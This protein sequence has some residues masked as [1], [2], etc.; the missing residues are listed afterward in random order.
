MYSFFK[1]GQCVGI[2]LYLLCTSISIK[3][4]SMILRMRKIQTVWTLT[5]KLKPGQMWIT[6]IN[7]CLNNASL[8]QKTQSLKS[9]Q[10]LQQHLSSPLLQD[11]RCTSSLYCVLCDYISGVWQGLQ[12]CHCTSESS[13]T[14]HKHLRSLFF[15]I[16][17]NFIFLFI[18]FYFNFI[19]FAF[20]V[21][22]MTGGKIHIIQIYIP[23]ITLLLLT[24]SL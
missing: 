21:I 15:A 19:L 22:I 8:C 14:H 1:C 20:L 2:L 18:F 17:P 16:S 9:V 11:H 4:L 13:I 10:P 24:Q 6:M 7:M 5:H 12:S 23:V 3:G